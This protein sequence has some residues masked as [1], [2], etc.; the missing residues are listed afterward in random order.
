MY[1]KVKRLE[2]FKLLS[3]SIWDERL[4]TIEYVYIAELFVCNT[5]YR[6]MTIFWQ[7]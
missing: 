6:H 7:E 5:H 3:R 4:R 1:L 2:K